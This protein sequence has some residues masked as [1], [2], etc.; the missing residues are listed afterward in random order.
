MI[1]WYWILKL[2]ARF[3]AGDFTDALAAA[4]KAKPWLDASAGQ[5]QQ[6]DYFYY[7]ALTVSALFESASA[8]QQQAWSELLTAHCAQLSECAENYP[9][10]FGD[11]HALVAAEIDR[12]ERRM[13]SLVGVPQLRGDEELVTWDAGF[14]DGA[15]HAA[16]VAVERRGI[17]VAVADLE[18]VTDD[19][20]RLV[21][22][23]A[24]HAEAELGDG[25]AVVEGER[26]N[27]RHTSTL[28]RRRPRCIVQPNGC[29]Y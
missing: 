4:D 5:I 1:C 10:T 18:R 22:I 28:T 21:G 9:P 26:G 12:I 6:V 19:P 13:R 16:L 20:L 2:K 11:K 7:T 27:R 8:E 14:L 15:T 3:L 29:R 17:D 24:E 23:D 25:V